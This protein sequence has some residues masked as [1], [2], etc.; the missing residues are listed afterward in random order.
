MKM[1]TMLPC[2]AALLLALPG[3]A[4]AMDVAAAYRQALANDPSSLAAEQAVLAGRELAVQ[5]DA[6][7]RPQVNLQASVNRIQNR[8][9]GNLAP[10]A[11]ELL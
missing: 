1:L 5:G 3:G 9:N 7:L 10:P 11:S 8:L 4:H 2:A 6:L